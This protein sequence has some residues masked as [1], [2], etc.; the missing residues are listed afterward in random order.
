[1]ELGHR[2]ACP[3]HCVNPDH[4]ALATDQQNAIYSAAHPSPTDR[5]WRTT[6]RLC[7]I[8]GCDHKHVARG[9]CAKHVDQRVELIRATHAEEFGEDFTPA[10]CR[11]RE[12]RF[13]TIISTVVV[14]ANQGADPVE[15]LQHLG[16]G[17]AR[18]K[19]YEGV[20]EATLSAIAVGGAGTNS[21]VVMATCEDWTT[22][23][24]IQQ[25]L[26]TDSEMIQLMLEGGKMA[27]WQ[28]FTSQTIDFDLLPS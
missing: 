12:R 10:G 15:L 27:T 22:Y 17:L 2:N 20:Q 18:I 6:Q 28:S 9:V 14:T 3:H 23:G 1:M 5:R 4:W 26:N 8:D 16:K 24:K 21:M 19:S 13:M 7:V 25:E 11:G